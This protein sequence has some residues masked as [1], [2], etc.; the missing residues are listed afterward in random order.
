MKACRI[1]HMAASPMRSRRRGAVMVAAI[2]C[3]GVTMMLLATMLRG[4]VAERRQLRYDHW[5]R[6][7]E[8]LSHSGVERAVHRL[9]TDPQFAGETWKGADD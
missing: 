8:W 6:Q 9:R 3:M 2:I 1:S 4:A 5:H 7:A